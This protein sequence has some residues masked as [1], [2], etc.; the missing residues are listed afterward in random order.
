MCGEVGDFASAL[1]RPLKR[2]VGRATLDA[3]AR[4][5]DRGGSGN[6][7]TQAAPTWEPAISGERPADRRDFR[8]LA[9]ASALRCSFRSGPWEGD[10]QEGV[11]SRSVTYLLEDRTGRCLWVELE[12]R[13]VSVCDGDHPFERTFSDLAEARAYVAKLVLECMSS[14]FVSRRMEPSGTPE[15]KRLLRVREG[16][17]D[18]RSMV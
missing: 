17:A 4:E 9:E 7:R 8:R 15:A 14:G 2:W 1:N 3:L 11:V 10:S 12:G 5:R 16:E 13:L 18:E 6:G